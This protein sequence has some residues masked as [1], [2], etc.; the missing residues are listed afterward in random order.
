MAKKPLTRKRVVRT[1]VA[2]EPS[3]GY[4]NQDPDVGPVEKEE[5]KK[6]TFVKVQFPHQKFILE[7]FSG[8]EVVFRVVQHQNGAQGRGLFETEDPILAEAIR[9]HIKYRKHLYV[10]AE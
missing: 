2:Q 10:S 1:E 4:V 7:E 9:E 6:F 5:P 3:E 8:Y